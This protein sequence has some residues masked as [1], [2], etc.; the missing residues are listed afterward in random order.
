MTTKSLIEE[1]PEAPIGNHV[2]SESAVRSKVS[3]VGNALSGWS[4]W[5]IRDLAP[6]GGLVGGPFGSSLGTKDYVGLGVPV[7]RGQNLGSDGRFDASDFVYVSEGKADE[8]KRNIAVAGDLVFTQRGT[9]GQVGIVPVGDFER[10]VISQ[11]QMRLRPDPELAFVDFLYYVFRSPQ[12]LDMIDSRAIITGVPHI[13]L[14]ILGD[15]PVLLPPLAEQR[16][17]AGVL[18]ALDDKIESNRRKIAIAQGLIHTEFLSSIRNGAR[19]GSLGDVLTELRSK[20]AGDAAEV[21]VFSALAEGRLAVSDD[22]F[23]KKVYSAEIDKYL[24]VP[25][26]A[27]AYNPSRI[28][29]G[30]IGLNSSTT[31]G[32]VSPVYVVAQAQTR[33]IARWVE[34]ALRTGSL[35]DKIVAYSSGSVRQVLRYS[36]FAAIELR[37][38][39]DA[40]LSNFEDDTLQL[41]DLVDTATQ[42]SHS[43]SIMRDALLPELLSGRLRVRDAESMMENV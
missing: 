41:F 40:A 33:A 36:D 3:S 18:G 9:L 24:K 37:L 4:E 13:N 27:F 7:I 31:I 30:S 16:A 19:D 1:F 42:E 20:V 14:G 6:K 12:M 25:Q 26:W 35:R 23:T 21:V 39:S 34:Q 43:L 8:L 28:N 17:I 11:S 10:Y 22:F 5:I 32:A 38:P 15:F 2:N 29:I